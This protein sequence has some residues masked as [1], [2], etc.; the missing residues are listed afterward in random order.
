M[1]II[2]DQDQCLTLQVGPGDLLCWNEE[3]GHLHH[4]LRVGQPPPGLQSVSAQQGQRLWHEH[5]TVW[6][7]AGKQ[8]VPEAPSLDASTSATVEHHWKTGSGELR[9]DFVKKHGISEEGAT[10]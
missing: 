7:E 3:G 6:S 5:P 4:Q 10:F 1:V 9:V 2:M 8:D